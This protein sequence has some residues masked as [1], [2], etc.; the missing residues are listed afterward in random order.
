MIL[1]PTAVLDYIAKNELKIFKPNQNHY[2]NIIFDDWD[3]FYEK[4]YLKFGIEFLIDNQ[5]LKN[6]YMKK[7]NN[8]WE[9]GNRYIC[10]SLNLTNFNTTTIL[11][12]SAT[13]DDLQSE[14]W[15]KHFRLSNPNF[16]FTNKYKT[17][18]QELML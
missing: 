9:T 2:C 3:E 13:E 18:Y 1:T 17:T 10:V 12:R 4:F 16:I 8:V 14:V 7:P 15:Q 6:Q 5:R 11:V